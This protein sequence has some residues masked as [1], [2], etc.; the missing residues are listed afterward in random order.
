MAPRSSSN[1]RRLYDHRRLRQN[2]RAV[3]FPERFETV[4]CQELQRRSTAHPA[5]PAAAETSADA[6]RATR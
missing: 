4:V 6:G 3:A 1:V 5:A 2:L